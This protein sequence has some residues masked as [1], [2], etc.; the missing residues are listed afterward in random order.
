MKKT[1][2]QRLF[3]AVQPSIEVV[4]EL[5]K[6]I[7][8]LQSTLQGARLS[9]ARPE[10]LHLTLKFLGSTPRELR[11]ALHQELCQV[12]ERFQ[13]FEMHCSGIG[14]FPGSRSPRVIWAGIS[15]PVGSLVAI[16]QML[17]QRLAQHGFSVEKRP[18]SPHITLA[19]IR[20]SLKLGDRLH[21]YHSSRWGK[22]SVSEILLIESITDPQCSRY[23]IE[24][25]YPLTL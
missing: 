19:R 23:T 9:W 11:P 20:E 6:T 25:R 1:E 21:R 15:D 12:V 5:E 8:E 22:S 16:A 24:E 13:S 17:D 14:V 7:H 3:L 10:Q 2:V 18:F 4:Q